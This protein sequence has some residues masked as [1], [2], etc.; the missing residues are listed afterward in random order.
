M[1]ILCLKVQIHYDHAFAISDTALCSFSFC[2]I[3]LV[4]SKLNLNGYSVHMKQSVLTD[5]NKQCSV[6]FASISAS[7]ATSELLL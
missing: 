3:M 7:M 4:A 1:K 5:M 2:Y 6:L